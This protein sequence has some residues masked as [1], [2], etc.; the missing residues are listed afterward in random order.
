MLSR[1]IDVVGVLMF[2]GAGVLHVVRYSAIVSPTIVSP[3]AEIDA[4]ITSVDSSSVAIRIFVGRDVSSFESKIVDVGTG[5]AKIV[6]LVSSTVL[7]GVTMHTEVAVSSRNSVL[8]RT[9]ASVRVIT[10]FDE[11][12]GVGGAPM[13][14]GRRKAVTI[15]RIR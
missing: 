11:G 2:D 14:S 3:S 8:V 10:V 4:G 15:R 1:G 13:T 12:A 6:V 5:H 7:V 9:A